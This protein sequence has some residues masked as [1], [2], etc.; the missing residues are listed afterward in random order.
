MPSAGSIDSS[1]STDMS[2]ALSFR[3]SDLRFA[4]GLKSAREP[5]NGLA[6]SDV[7]L[8]DGADFR[9]RSCVHRIFD[10]HS[11]G[12]GEPFGESLSFSQVIVPA[13]LA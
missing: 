12:A 11:F 3:F 2:G 9:S 8:C 1:S 4:L 5:G 10:C 6:D 7:P 13:A